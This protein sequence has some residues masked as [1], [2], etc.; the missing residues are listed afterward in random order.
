M[1]SK[2]K[3]GVKEVLKKDGRKADKSVMLEIPEKRENFFAG[4]LSIK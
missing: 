2:L 1:N 4:I 3:M